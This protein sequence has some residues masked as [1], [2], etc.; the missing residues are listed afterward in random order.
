MAHMFRYSNRTYS[1]SDKNTDTGEFVIVKIGKDNKVEGAKIIIAK[2]E[3]HI[4]K[5]VRSGN[6]DRFKT[7][8]GSIQ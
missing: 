5:L 1:I 4:E 8:E 7:L 6:F 3:Q 2:T